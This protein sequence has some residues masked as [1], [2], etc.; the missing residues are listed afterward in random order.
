M[1]RFDFRTESF[2]VKVEK[3][4]TAGEA[5]A[6][7]WRGMIIHVGSGRRFYFDN[8]GDIEVLMRP[9][10]KRLGIGPCDKEKDESENGA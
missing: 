2:I 7:M 6:P 3:L 5:A 1:D 10:L 8:L 4:E 9:H